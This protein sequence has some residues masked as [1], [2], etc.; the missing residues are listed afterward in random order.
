MYNVYA[1]CIITGKISFI[2]NFET[3]EDAIRHI[4]KCYRI[5]KELGYLG[6]FYY[7]MRGE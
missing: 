4:A 7:Y 2:R 1:E 6:E 5:D 3:K